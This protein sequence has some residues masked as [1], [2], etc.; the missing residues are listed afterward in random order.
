MFF[1]GVIK[2]YDRLF[3]VGVYALFLRVLIYESAFFNIL[4]CRK[5]NSRGTHF[6]EHSLDHIA[7]NQFTKMLHNSSHCLH[8][9]VELRK[10]DILFNPDFNLFPGDHLGQV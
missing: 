2:R 3:E 4:N 6:L 1:D 9:T 8:G 5:L 7:V 10:I